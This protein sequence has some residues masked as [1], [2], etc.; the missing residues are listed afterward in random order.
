[1]RRAS[2]MPVVGGHAALRA[3]VEAL[4]QTWIDLAADATQ[5][6]GRL[7]YGYPMG[8]ALVRDPLSP[9]LR[10]SGPD[11]ERFK[12][13]RSMRDVEHVSSVEILDPFGNT[14]T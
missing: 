12:A 5:N 3:H 8:E 14:I 7:F 11:Y 6:G 13:S 10:A 1:M 4:V 9:L 2:A